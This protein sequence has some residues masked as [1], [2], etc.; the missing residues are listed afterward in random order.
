MISL[1]RIILDALQNAKS[2]LSDDAVKAIKDFVLKHNHNEG[3]FV[4]KV[5]NQDIYYTVFG[6]TLSYILNLHIDISK[7]KKYLERIKNQDLDFIHSI[8]YLRCL[9]LI[10]AISFSQKNTRLSNLFSGS[11]FITNQLF[12]NLSKEI[13]KNNA[14]VFSKINQY[15]TQDSGYNQNEIQAKNST[16]YANYIVWMFL[17]DFGFKFID[18]QYIDIL[19]TYQSTNGGFVNEIGS[20]STVTTATSAG[21]ILQYYLW[22]SKNDNAIQYL[23]NQQNKIGGFVA[24]EKLPIADLLSTSS[25]LLA[26]K[27]A[28]NLNL[29]G[30][31]DCLKFIDLHWNE[32]GGFIGSISDDLPDC[33]YTFYALLAIGIL[34]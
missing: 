33:E 27:I 9:L 34:I 16:I 29:V 21:V 1:N 4:D 18:E 13:K 8:S 28:E 7:E 23:L 24:G 26:L 30:K 32:S 31:E 14:S 11:D 5:G 6:Y 19:K 15:K 20:D 3:G 2:K 25:A 12:G 17:G 10:E 22:K